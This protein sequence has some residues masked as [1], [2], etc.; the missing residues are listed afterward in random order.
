M[1]MSFIREVMYASVEN[2]YSDWAHVIRPYV[3]TGYYATGI[4]R[5]ILGFHRTK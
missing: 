1:Q 3:T 5:R 4:K 2:Q